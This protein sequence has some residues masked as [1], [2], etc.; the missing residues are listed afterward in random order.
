MS[1]KGKGKGGKG[2]SKGGK[3]AP[4][5]R[6]T[7]AGLQFPVGRV[8]RY[9][10]KGRYAGRIGTTAAVYMAAVL[11]YLTAEVLELAG[12]A[13]IDLKRSRITNRHIQLAVSNDEEIDKLFNKCAIPGGGVRPHIHK[14]LLPKGKNGKRAQKKSKKKSQKKKVKKKRS[15]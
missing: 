7:S 2:K 6:S 13:C 3:K 11:E 1:G 8:S 12:N 9:L 15:K 4:V 5:S 10:R 14:S